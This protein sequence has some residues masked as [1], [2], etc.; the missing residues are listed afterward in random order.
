MFKDV[1]KALADLKAGKL[2]VV[3][4]DDDR[5]AEGDLVGLAELASADNVNF[6]TKN[7]RG[8]ICA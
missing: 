7:A 3:V 6:M 2:I 4:D 1:E 5:E 8:L